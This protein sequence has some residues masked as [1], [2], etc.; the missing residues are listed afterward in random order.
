LNDPPTIDP[1]GVE[2]MDALLGFLKSKGVEVFL[3]HPPFNPLFYERVKT[4]SYIGG[5]RKVEELTRRFAVKHGYKVIG[6]FDPQEVGCDASMYIDAEHGNPT[7]LGRLLEQY[8]RL[9]Q[10]RQ[11]SKQPE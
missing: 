8:R 5:L 4:G 1:K 11:S 10:P 3:V 2:A 9:D 6:S 7:C